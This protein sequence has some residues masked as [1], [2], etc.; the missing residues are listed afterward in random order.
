MTNQ[1]RYELAVCEQFEKLAK[2][3][4]MEEIKEVLDTWPEQ[5]DYNTKEGED[6]SH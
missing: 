1:D 2:V 3:Q 4:T 6:E 5:E